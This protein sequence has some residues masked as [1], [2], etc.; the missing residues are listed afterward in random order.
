MGWT[1]K[2]KVIYTGGDIHK[3]LD[4]IPMDEGKATCFIAYWT[5]SGR[6]LLVKSSGKPFNINI[7]H[8]FAPT[9]SR[10]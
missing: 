4:E 2:Y 9:Q 3:I 10:R 8:M 1:G 5:I 7:V 6:I